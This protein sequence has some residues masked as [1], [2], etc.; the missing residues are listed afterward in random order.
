MMMANSVEGRFPFLDYRVVEFCAKLPARLKL[1]VMEEKYLL[2]KIAGPYLPQD[3]LKRKKQAYRAPDSA[4]FFSGGQ[5]L[6]YVDELLSEKNL[7]RT[8][9]FDPPGGN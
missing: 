3:I 2:K 7:A 4:S 9:Y 1:K 8:N 6:T 5:G